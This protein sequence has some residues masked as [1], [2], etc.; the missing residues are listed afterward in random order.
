M[1]NNSFK[2]ISISKK[3]LFYTY[4][5]GIFLLIALP[6]N[7][8]K[9]L[10]NITILRLRG[11]YFFHILLF[12]PWAFFHNIAAE[13]LRLRICFWPLAISFWSAAKPTA[14]SQKPTAIL[15][16]P[17]LVLRCRHRGLAVF[18]ALAGL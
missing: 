10:N 16:P 9:E 11:D 5:F 4:L 13:N 17:R 14:K 12:L 8:A 2:N 3:I 15:A 6:L 1:W 18:F 7:T